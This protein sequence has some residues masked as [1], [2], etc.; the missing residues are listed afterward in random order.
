MDRSRHVVHA[1]KTTRLSAMAVLLLA[2][3]GVGAQPQERPAESHTQPA[4]NAQRGMKLYNSIG[5]SG[6]HGK[7][8]EGGSAGSR[9]AQNAVPLPAFIESVRAPAGAMPRY[10]TQMV[11]DAQLADIHAFLRTVPPAQARPSSSVPARAGD[12]ENGRK[13]YNAIGCWSCHG[14]AAQ[15]ARTGPR[16]APNPIP[17]AAFAN[18]IRAPGGDM[19]PYTAKVVSDAELR[20][21]YAFLMTIPPPREVSDIPP[22]NQ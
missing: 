19:P 12:P 20:D 9:L 10:T 15:G 1:R 16:L 3:F 17:F 8:G 13:L 6:C 4:G 18:Y 11:S 14:Y 7:S 2:S 22:L 21:I 5:C